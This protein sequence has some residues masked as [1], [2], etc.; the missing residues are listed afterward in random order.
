MPSSILEEA[1]NW[2]E[3]GNSGIMASTLN[4][5]GLSGAAI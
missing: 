5:R 1:W 3:G 2:I 4:V